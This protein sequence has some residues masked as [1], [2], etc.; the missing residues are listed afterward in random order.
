M[1]NM[2]KVVAIEQAI[3]PTA[4]VAG[5]TDINGSI[6]DMAG[7]DGILMQVTFGAITAGAVTSIK[8]QQGQQSG[9]GDQADLAGTAQT[10]ADTDDDKVFYIDLV[11]PLERYVRLVVDR[12]TQNAVVA[13]AVYYKYRE[14]KAPVTHG[15]GVAGET[16]I[17]PAE[18][19]A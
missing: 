17:S 13:S 1:D 9:G 19:T 8:A 10:I 2:S 3:T 16:H 18:G 6:A 15:S 14:R 11:G 12:G 5:T 4:G 7:F